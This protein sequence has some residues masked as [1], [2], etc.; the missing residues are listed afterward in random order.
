MINFYHVIKSS[1]EFKRLLIVFSI[2][3]LVFSILVYSIYYNLG[4]KNEHAQRVIHSQER[5]YQIERVV[6][7]AKDYETGARGFVITNNAA[8][9]EPF[10]MAEDSLEKV[11][12]HLK[13]LVRFD[14]VQENYRKLLLQHLNKK[15]ALSRLTIKVRQEKGLDAALRLVAT[16]K[17][18]IQMDKIR[19]IVNA[20]HAHE[21]SVLK[22]QK[23]ESEEIAFQINLIL[24][25][26]LALFVLLLIYVLKRGWTNLADKKIAR[27]QLQ[28]SQDR[29]M[30]LIENSSEAIVLRDEHLNIVY[31]SS[32]AERIFGFT[33]EEAAQPGFTL[34]SYPAKG[35]EQVTQ[36]NQEVLSSPGQPIQKLIQLQHKSGHLVWVE[37]N[38]TNLLQQPSIRAIVSHFGDVTERVKDALAVQKANSLLEKAISNEQRR[39][40]NLFMQAPVSICVFKGADHRYVLTNL[41]FD[42]LIGGRQVLGKTV[43]EAFPDLAHQA[44]QEKLDLVYKTGES[45]RETEQVLQLGRDSN[46]QLNTIYLD[47]LFQPYCNS[48][49]IVEEI[50][51]FGVDVSE[52]VLTRKRIEESEWNFRQ[53]IQDL[54][55]AV[56]TCDVN[57]CIKLFNKAAVELW[58]REPDVDQEFWCGSHN[59]YNANGQILARENC[60]MALA[61]SNKVAADN[62]EIIMECPDGSRRHIMPHTVLSHDVTGQVTGGINILIDITESKITSEQIR[63]S[64]AALTEAQRIAKIGSWNLDVDTRKLSCSE[65]LYR[66]FDIDAAY[67]QAPS[68]SFL[69]FVDEAD[70][71]LIEQTI[72]EA[73]TNGEPFD[74]ECRI[75]TLKGEHRNLH[76]LGNSQTD[77]N[78]LIIRLYG[79]S[80]DI[81]ERKHAE[82]R[83]QE[84]EKNIKSILTSSQEAIYLLDVNCRLVLLNEQ[85]R[86][87]IKQGYGVDC[88]IGDNFPALFESELQDKLLSVYQ[89]VLAG[90]K[91]EDERSLSLKEDVYH[92]TYFP[93]RDNEGNITGLCC[94]AKDITERRKIEKA[95]DIAN[96]EKEEFQYRFKAIL[97]YSPQSILIKDIEGK[98]IFANKAFLTLF[99]L[100]QENERGNQLKAISDDQAALAEFSINEN[101]G[102]PAIKSMEWNQQIVL[103]DGQVLEME[104]VKFPLYDR[105]KRLFGIC[106][107][108]KDITEQVKH[109]QQLI[110]AR[111]NAE[112]AERLQ[113]QFLANMSHEL[114][115]PMNGIIGM[116]NLLLVSSSLQPDQKGRLQIIKQSSN[117]LLSLINN[118]LDLSKLKAGILTLEEL[119]FDF[120]ESIAGTIP[121]FKERAQEKGLR[122][123]ASADHFIPELLVGDPHRLNQ[124]LSNLL[125]N[126]I[127]FTEKGFVR[128]EASLQSKTPDQVVIEFVVTDSGVGIDANSLHYIFDNFAQGSTDIASKYGGTGLGLAI[129]RRLIEMQGG[130]ISVES[131]KGKGTSFSFCLPYAIAKDSDAVV[132]LY[133][134]N[135]PS[136]LKKSYNGKRAL[137]VEDNDIN[138]AVLASSLKQF[139]IDLL[140]AQHGGEA[141]QILE[142]G[143]QFDIIFMDLRMPVMNGFEAI[144]YIRQKLQLE[145]PIVVLTASVLRNEKERCLEIG[146]SDYM[147]K[148]FDMVDLARAL[149]QFLSISQQQT[150][151][152]YQV[153]TNGPAI[154]VSSTTV[155]SPSTATVMVSGFDISR[156]LELEDPEYIRMVF[157]L[158][159]EK[160]PSYLQE[161]KSILPSGNCKDFLEK[162]HKAKGSLASVYM[163]EMYE[164]IVEME[165][166][167]HGQQN[168][169]GIEPLLDRCLSLYPKLLP[170]IQQEVEKQLITI[171]ANI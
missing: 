20:M 129:T 124:I 62:L 145:I 130:T 84:S 87:V 1:Q 155:I 56:Y 169:D 143:E 75:T 29:F 120:N 171:L 18:K 44:F 86:S 128:L 58:G 159:V 40:N 54:P 53:L 107:L 61:L 153:E 132:N 11:F 57:G 51:F 4:W 55:A 19:E 37:S 31:W 97:D 43:A 89:K 77:A 150:P 90:E 41:L 104:I 93:V 69:D 114:R 158:F 78:G 45:Y 64:E 59:L 135:E 166:K 161:L 76:L 101:E 141:I 66:I 117:T 72:K 113:E 144:T 134:R 14:S 9:K 27:E 83:L 96:A 8:Y 74:V 108:A 2:I 152:H 119:A 13:E 17:G 52:Q 110:Q 38:T 122:L 34:L 5:I 79:T 147:A 115:T 21:L 22:K 28:Q 138:Q 148:P 156:L 32:T 154:A 63:Q 118:I 16:N 136:P 105:H 81:T 111:E 65:Q 35:L 121:F 137:I 88:K 140:I 99:N 139:H 73:L 102:P 146:A 6:S 164:L 106:T 82:M 109:Q 3:L 25:L 48:D 68:A 133:R 26:G 70:R 123:V 151:K 127:K 126:A 60:P 30:A 98:Y 103:S 94:S 71:G 149:E 24:L 10:K 39:F 170:A 12:S 167:V 125:S 92:S 33:K 142:S 67:F 131:T 80:Q 100:D 7:L 157:D 47:M 42:R 95:M 49:G 162:A 85:C 36:Y 46:G 50:Y 160:M 165:K 116:A 23:K 91:W 15:I 112:H 163:E 168:M